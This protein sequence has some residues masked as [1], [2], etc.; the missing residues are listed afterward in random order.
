MSSD[1]GGQQTQRNNVADNLPARVSP[2][3]DP[4]R[5]I[6]PPPAYRSASQYPRAQMD[7]GGPGHAGFPPAPHGP[8]IPYDRQDMRSLDDTAHQQQPWSQRD[9]EE[10]NQQQQAN[11]HQQQQ[12]SAPYSN[13]HQ[14]GNTYN[15]GYQG[16]HPFQGYGE[17]H[18]QQAPPY[19]GPPPPPGNFSTHDQPVTQWMG[20][21]DGRHDPPRHDPPRHDHRRGPD[22]APSPVS[23]WPRSHF[24]ADF[25]E[26][27][28]YE[29]SNVLFSVK[30]QE[31]ENKGDGKLAVP[32]CVMAIAE[33]IQKEFKYTINSE[34]NKGQVVVKYL[35][36]INGFL[37]TG[38][39][40]FCSAFIDKRD[41]WTLIAY[42]T[43]ETLYHVVPEPFIKKEGKGGSTGV[44]WGQVYPSPGECAR[45][46]EIKQ[47]VQDEMVKC[48]Y[49]VTRFEHAL[50]K[51]SGTDLETDW[52]DMGFDP[53][54]NV[55]NL[56]LNPIS[57][58]K[59]V[60]MPASGLKLNISFSREFCEY[61]GIARCCNLRQVGV[62]PSEKHPKLQCSC[63]K[64]KGP[65]RR[66]N[67][68]D[69]A[70]NKMQARERIQ[71]R[72]QQAMLNF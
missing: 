68:A 24:D 25:V 8:P 62:E 50:D 31:P 32:G 49:T 36:G 69:R 22:S 18:Y 20:G 28:D 55:V 53:D 33:K 5:L 37:M 47:V 66:G 64:K 11:W 51:K 59:K 61:H 60:T 7:Y 30:R 15:T 72:Q 6:P 19:A 16:N 27:K 70:R 38:P 67:N 23:R 3:P 42:G 39:E 65:D 71:H 9:Q 2:A 52:Y 63:S 46:G 41:L 34:D 56:F 58:L 40:Y 13:A 54:H 29:N 48:G 45:I 57:I 43:D 21:P 35:K 14:G 26:G 1:Q 12:R 4:S 44:N 10:W 17:T